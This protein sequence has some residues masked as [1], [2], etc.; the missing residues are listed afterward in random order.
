MTPEYMDALFERRQ[1][2]DPEERN[3]TF[4]SL[5]GRMR[6]FSRGTK[7]SKELAEGFFAEVEDLIERVEKEIQFRRDASRDL[8]RD[9][10]HD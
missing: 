8:R 10:G 6:A 5:F 3:G 4:P 2:L 7:T 9:C 1:N